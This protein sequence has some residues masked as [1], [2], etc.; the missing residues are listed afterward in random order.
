M[1]LRLILTILIAPYLLAA[2]SSFT[3]FLTSIETNNKSLA[4][5]RSMSKA[6]QLE[7]KTGIYL[8]NPTVSYDYLSGNDINYS[9]MV[10]SQAFDFP[11]VYSNKNKIADFSGE[12]STEQYRYIR[13]DLL[14]D[15]SK[16][17]SQQVIAERK[18]SLLTELETMLDKLSANAERKLELG[19]SNILETNRIRT[20][21]AKNKVDVNML[22]T[23][24]NAL[25]LKI[26]ELNGGENYN[27]T[28]PTDLSIALPVYTDSVISSIVQ[29][30]PSY[31]YWEIELEKSAKEIQLQKAISLPKMELGYR[32]DKA[33]DGTF[34]GIAAGISIPLFENKNTVKLAKAQ[35]LYAT[36]EFEMEKL[37]LK[38]HIQQLV[39]SHETLSTALTEI[40]QLVN[41]QNM[42]PLLLKAYSSGQISYTEFFSEYSIYKDTQLYIED[43]RLKTMA[44]EMQLYVLGNY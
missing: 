2:Q 26:T 10:I 39:N 36:E 17:Y 11:T 25:K 27:Y 13:L 1:K 18:L 37:D 5:A 44:I 7:A 33:A 28:D 22:K 20:E 40:E 31:K 16:Y 38:T 41:E 30:H 32:Q 23:Q 21:R 42:A 24:S 19:E 6:E 29:N 4:A 3:D 8:E 12:Q 14:N 35:Q 15:A 34:N 9:E 43:L